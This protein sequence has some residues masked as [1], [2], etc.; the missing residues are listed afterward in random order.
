MADSSR[1][2]RKL[3]PRCRWPFQCPVEQSDRY[4]CRACES[5]GW[6]Q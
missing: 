4:F 6:K 2:I 1:Y 3:C 5:D